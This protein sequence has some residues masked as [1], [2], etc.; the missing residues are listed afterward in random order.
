MKSKILITLIFG[1]LLLAPVMAL[2]DQGFGKQNENFTFSQPCNEATFIT[3]DIILLP[4]KKSLTINQNM[5]FISGGTFQF[6][7]TDTSQLGR[8]DVMGIS[9]GCENTFAT[10]FTITTTGFELET[11]EGNIYIV[12]LIATFILFLAFL[13]P[14]IKLPYSNKTDNEGAV[15]SITKAK[16]LKL[17]SIWFAYGFLMWFLQTLNSI[18]TAFLKLTHLSNFIT[19]IFTY[20]NWF[21]VGITFLILAIIF[22]EIWKDIILS[23][24]IKKFGKALTNGKLQ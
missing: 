21:S 10:F 9:D 23:N 7:I 16:Y 8:Y 4:D 13:F 5:T 1:M 15:V 24:T 2:D 6:N 14:A 22:I 3:L 11:A 20:S 19:K 17:L 12:V 18:T